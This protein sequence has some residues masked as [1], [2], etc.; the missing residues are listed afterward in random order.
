MQHMLHGN[1]MQHIQLKTSCKPPFSK[2]KFR[3]SIGLLL[4]ADKSNANFVT[5]SCLN[6]DAHFKKKDELSVIFITFGN[7]D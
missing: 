4:A 6:N 3:M 5:F 7:S 2:T 1:G